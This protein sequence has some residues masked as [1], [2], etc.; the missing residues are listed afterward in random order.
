V[1]GWTYKGD[2]G[3]VE[4]VEVIQERSRRQLVCGH[5]SAIIHRG[6]DMLRWEKGGETFIRCRLRECKPERSLLTTSPIK[7]EVWKRID[8][9]APVG[10]TPADVARELRIFAN[11]FLSAV[12]PIFEGLATRARNAGLT[13]IEADLTQRLSDLGDYRQRLRDEATLIE[14]MVISRSLSIDDIHDAA[15]AAV[16]GCEE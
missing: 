8:G 9:F 5:C 13:E 1:K 10:T 4:L 6:E 2:R 14:S 16:L 12:T 15:A 7:A 3:D 11:V